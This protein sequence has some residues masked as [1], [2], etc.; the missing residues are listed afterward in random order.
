MTPQVALNADLGRYLWATVDAIAKE[1]RCTL[2]NYEAK[3]ILN[4][5]KYTGLSLFVAAGF[6]LLFG[7][8]TG[9]ESISKPAAT[10]T[11]SESQIKRAYVM[12]C[13]L[14]H[15]NDGKLMASKAPD[16]S[17]STLSFE[18]RVAIISYGKG[19][20]PPQKDILNDATIR[21][22]ANFIEQFRD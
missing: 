12:K 1:T 2:L 19:T 3:L 7:C 13:A 11:P 9:G 5:F 15:G 8:G 4:R 18:E 17:L 6:L 16:L 22:I 10:D 14:C 21:G 20:M